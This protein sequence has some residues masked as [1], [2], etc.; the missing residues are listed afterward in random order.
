MFF[1]RPSSEHVRIGRVLPRVATALLLMALPA[2]CSDEPT[3]DVTSDADAGASP[4][5]ADV[6]APDAE[7][8]TDASSD[9]PVAAPPLAVTCSVTPCARDLSAS[10]SESFC[11]LLDDGRVACWGRNLHGELGYDAGESSATATPVDGVTKAVALD[12]TCAVVE[13]GRVVCWGP[14]EAPAGDEGPPPNVRSVRVGA[15][16]ACAIVNDGNVACWGKKGDDGILAYADGGVG[17]SMPPSII[18]LGGPV[19]E[20]AIARRTTVTPPPIFCPT[21]DPTI[22]ESHAV[23]ARRASGE[24]LSW[25]QVPLIGRP[26]EQKPD[27]TTARVVDRADRVFGGYGGCVVTGSS[28]GCWG[29]GRDDNDGDLHPLP[30]PLVPHAIHATLGD[31]GSGRFGR[32]CAVTPAGDVYCWGRNDHG[33]AGDG[34]QAFRDLPVKVTNLPEPTVRV[35]ATGG[36]TCALGVSGRVYCWGDD[37]FGQRG[38]KTP[39]NKALTPLPVEFP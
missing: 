7:G 8:D 35:E 22:T 15:G 19:E 29:Y 3:N 9:A 39:F 13:G 16:F 18:Q 31:Y 1:T 17:E 23:L 11:A 14:A 25:G 24:V 2:S 5:D 34:T 26:T 10:W 38:Q 36:T 33:Q 4:P 6:V 37:A 12:R 20:I 30:V 28:L 21:R 32:G 27:A